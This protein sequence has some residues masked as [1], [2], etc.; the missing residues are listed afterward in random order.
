V[1]A[2]DPRFSVLDRDVDLEP[3]WQVLEAQPDFSRESTASAM[4]FVKGLEPRLGL[5]IRLPGALESLTPGERASFSNRCPARKADIDKVLSGLD[6]TR[7]TASN[8]VLCAVP[9]RPPP[10]GGSR[11]LVIGIAAGIVAAASLLVVTHSVVTN[12]DKT[13]DFKR[14]DAAE[15][16]GDIPIGAARVWGGEV[17]AALVAPTWMRQPA[18]RRRRQLAAA[19]D[20]LSSRQI[21]TLILQDDAM[22][23]KATAQIFGSNRSIQVHFY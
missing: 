20:R 16:A 18:E 23:T 5:Q 6:A 2:S 22:K 13:P 1:L 14:I 21:R 15:F 4:C 7:L 3:V 11:R 9:E 19:L 12:I 8:A 10:T 17:R